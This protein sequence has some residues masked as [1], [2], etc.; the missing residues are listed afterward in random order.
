MAAVCS[1]LVF[2]CESRTDPLKFVLTDGDAMP[3]SSRV[4]TMLFIQLSVVLELALRHNSI[5]DK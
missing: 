5:V 1:D 4:D 2:I 3:C